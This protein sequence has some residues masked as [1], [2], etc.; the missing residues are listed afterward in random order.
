MDLG[1]LVR[2]Y[3]VSGPRYTSY[4][5][6]PQWNEQVATDV[7]RR[8][9]GCF[10]N[11]GSVAIYVH[12][13]FCESLCLYC[14]CNIHLTHDHG[15]SGRYV[16]RVIEEMRNVRALLGVRPRASQVAWGGGTPTFL[17]EEQLCRLHEAI[18]TIFHVD[19]EAEVSIE[20]DPRVTSS[21]QLKTLRRIG[22]N[23]VSLG[24]QDFQEEVQRAVN[25]VQSTE[26]T[27][28]MLEL[29]RD[30]GFTGINYDLIYGLPLQTEISFKSTLDVV[31]SHR[32]DRIALYNYAHLPELRPH[33]RVLEKYDRPDSQMRISLFEMA[34]H[35]FLAEGYVAIGM[36]H[37][38][39]PHD[40]LAKALP[41]GSLYRNFQGYTVKRGLPLLGFGASAIS[42]F[43]NAYFQ[44]ERSVKRYEKRMGET[45]FATLRGCELTPNDLRSKWV[46]GELMCRFGVSFQDYKRRFQGDFEV[47]YARA[48][49]ELSPFK[50]DELC[51]LSPQ[52]IQ[53]T[54]YGRLFVRNVA[55][56][57]DEYVDKSG[58]SGTSGTYS[59]TL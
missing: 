26:S 5:T 28:G 44:N 29:C 25:R 14:G 39:L 43:E 6:A 4:P 16:S 22:F 3:S 36:D 52:G 1:A 21:D 33:Q 9:A 19:E 53:I 38:A 55:M 17:D 45:G 56:V 42:E 51:T 7:F 58:T 57:F 24:V 41:Q 59:K 13:P 18:T 48:V 11:E 47:D 27:R 34:Y 15:V 20:I 50:D 46:I 37:F 54:D 32:P 23:R 10:K 40:E 12:I 30:L 35:R 49:A 31:I 8:V 2:K